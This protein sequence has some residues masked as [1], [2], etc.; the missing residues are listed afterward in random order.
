MDKFKYTKEEYKSAW[1]SP[2][3]IAV[4]V[5]YLTMVIIGFLTPDDILS[6]HAWAR[7]FSDFMAAIVPQI[8][9]ITALN[10]K[11]DVNRFYFSVLWMGVPFLLIVFFT[12]G[13]IP[14]RRREWPIRER[15]FSEAFVAFIGMWLFIL[16]S[17]TLWSVDPNMKLA[18][19]QFGNVIGRVFI[20]QL[21][22]M[23]VPM[24]F[25]ASSVMAYGWLSG[26]SPKRIKEQIEKNN[27]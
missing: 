14:W 4:A 2:Y 23:C 20:A 10:I 19:F 13:L 8:D 15:S 11:P 1:A 17:M 3:G 16:W 9:H 7:E 27:G 24:L 12:Y 25:F 22:V 18:R 21:Y 26:E 6:N 5:Y